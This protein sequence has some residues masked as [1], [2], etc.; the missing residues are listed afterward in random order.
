MEMQTTTARGIEEPERQVVD[1]TQR[2]EAETR[3][4]AGYSQRPATSGQ[5]RTP[6]TARCSR[7]HATAG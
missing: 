5:T 1:A 7:Y 2:V 6:G 3:C 4:T